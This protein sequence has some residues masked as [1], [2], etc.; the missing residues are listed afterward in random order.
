VLLVGGDSYDYTDNLGLGSISFIPTHY[1]AT[2]LIPHTPSDALLADLDGDGLSDKAI[3]RWPVRS[4]GDLQAVVDKTIAWSTDPAPVANAVWATDSQDPNAASFEAQ[5]ERMI[6]ML[7]RAGWS[8]DEI[9]RV[10]FDEVVP[11]PGRS[12]ADTARA[13]IFERLAQG[14]SLTGFVGHGAPAMWTFQ[15]LLTPD[16]LAELDNEGR[17]TLI[18][19]MTCYTSYFVSPNS[20]TVAHR[21]MN[22]YREDAF[23]NP[24]P[25]STNGAVAI[26]GA[27]TLSA[28]DENGKVAHDVLHFQLQ[29]D[30]LGQ[31][32]R[33]AAVR[34]RQQGLEDQVINWTLLGDPTLRMD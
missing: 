17:P 22:G 19:T 5:A 11:D 12:V 15:G 24:V 34:A 31:A 6:D 4:H 29:G 28:Y 1:A 14:R 23:G 2:R 25:G 8:D 7:E 20:D 30:T 21:W 3:G 27:A 32:V 33:K 13:R 9:T 16:D 18:G 26:H 10:Y